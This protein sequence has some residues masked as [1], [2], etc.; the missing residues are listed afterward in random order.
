MY[1]RTNH[2]LRST[3]NS[4]TRRKLLTTSPEYWFHSKHENPETLTKLSFPFY[5]W[6]RF[7]WFSQHLSN[8]SDSYHQDFGPPLNLAC[9]VS[10]V[11]ESQE[12]V[13]SIHVGNV[14][15]GSLC[16]DCFSQKPS[17]VSLVQRHSLVLFRAVERLVLQQMSAWINSEYCEKYLGFFFFALEND[18]GVFQ[19]NKGDPQRSRSHC[20][21]V[22]GTCSHV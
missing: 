9:S 21:V 18:V 3:A 6:C 15:G 7:L 13:C 16:H 14:W 5:F 11:W 22:I 1:S 4:K 10:D 12:S 19:E 2:Y 17:A 20:G 8:S